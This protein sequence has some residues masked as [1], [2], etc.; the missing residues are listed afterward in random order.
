[1]GTTCTHILN[2]HVLLLN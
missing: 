2:P 1:M